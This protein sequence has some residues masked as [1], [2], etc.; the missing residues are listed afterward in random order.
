MQTDMLPVSVRRDPP[1]HNPIHE[2]NSTFHESFRSNSTVPPRAPLASEEFEVDEM[3]TSDMSS[4][5][6]LDETI[7]KVV[8][9]DD[10][11]GAYGG[12]PEDQQ[13]VQE[14]SWHDDAVPE[15]PLGDQTL[16][17]CPLYPCSSCSKDVH[18]ST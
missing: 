8:W 15:L 4:R 11:L 2:L 10:A 6:D 14:D 3:S 16:A 5:V 1:E 18:G 7:P 12:R 17:E 13:E 9:S